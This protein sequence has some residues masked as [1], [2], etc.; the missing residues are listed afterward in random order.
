MAVRSCFDGAQHERVLSAT[1]F[2][3]RP[4][5]VEG[6]NGDNTTH[7]FDSD[8]A[9]REGTTLHR[10][11]QQL[12]QVLIDLFHIVLLYAKQPEVAIYAVY[13]AKLAVRNEF[14]VIR[15]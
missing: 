9:L 10:Y 7:S 8:M 6:G 13:H 11:R 14:R 1:S 12:A 2:S 4:E 5:L 3:V 15:A